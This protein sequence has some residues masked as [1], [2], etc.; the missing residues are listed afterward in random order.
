MGVDFTCDTKTFGCSYS[1]WHYYRNL[2][3]EATLAYLDDYL[4]NQNPE[5]DTYE[6]SAMDKLKKGV[7][8]I[9]SRALKLS[10]ENKS[11]FGMDLG[12][13]PLE[14][15]YLKALLYELHE[16][17]WIGELIIEN[18]LNGIRALCNKSDCEGFYSVG[19]SYDICELLYK[20]R[21]F[22]IKNKENLEADE[23]YDYER[24]KDLLE[25]FEESVEKKII[26]R[27]H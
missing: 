25:M 14:E 16:N 11:I 8:S 26:V 27:I 24:S 5:I 22:L 20:I 4:A 2:I 12:K 13:R 15:C 1:G 7:A 17:E 18:G 21:P 3:I 9:R 6:F 10:T 19:N 23:N